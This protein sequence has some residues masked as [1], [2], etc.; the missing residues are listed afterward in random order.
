MINLS[1]KKLNF[2]KFL[3]VKLTN[4]DLYPHYLHGQDFSLGQVRDFWR[5]TVKAILEKKAPQKLGLYIH[6]PFCR[7]KC[8]FCSCDSY[9]PPSYKEVG[10]YLGLLK[11]EIDAFRDI[12]KRV[13]LTSVY[14]GGGSP[15]FLKTPDL[16]NLFRYLYRSFNI[17]PKAQLIFEGTPRDLNEENLAA[18]AKYGVNRLTIGVQSLD[19][20]VIKLMKRPQSKKDFIRVFKLARRLGIPYIN[21]DLIAGLEG[22]S[23][24]SF[25]SDLKTMLDLGADMIHVTG[26]TPLAHTPFCR[27]GKKLSPSQEENRKTMLAASR[28]IFKMVFKEIDC[29]NSGL[30]ERAENVQET[31]LRKE[32][33]SLLGIGY[34]AQS[35]AFSQAW[36]AHPH[37]VDLALADH[38]P[39]YKRL[40]VFT[41]VRGSLD[42]EMRK[43]IFSNLQRG[44]SRK[45]FSGLFGRDPVDFF[46]KEITALTAMGK[47]EIKGDRVISR[48]NGRQEFLVLSKIF[49]SPERIRAILRVHGKEYDKNKD[50]QTDLNILYDETD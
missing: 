15:S 46:R 3:T 28:K 45:F 49:Y 8:F 34:S 9:I 14:F 39:N 43:F 47:L 35:H 1:P 2:Y 29:E 22:Q 12:F 24:K 44:F 13:S 27:A 31:D 18:I 6:I 7:Q 25:L 30:S 17:H 21:I 50:Y 10:D 40:P 26:F 19:P 38:K 23:V 41:G 33:S 16:K 36:Y 37:L 42:E 11:R 32:N 20:K 48:I 4:D 5:K